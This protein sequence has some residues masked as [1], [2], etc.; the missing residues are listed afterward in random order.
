MK[1][2]FKQRMTKASFENR[3]VTDL[4]NDG[5]T[6][7]PYTEMDGDKVNKMTLYYKNGAHVGTWMGGS[8]WAFE[9]AYE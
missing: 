9:S 4:G 5:L 1:L 6:A 7:S 2:K 8:G 3:I